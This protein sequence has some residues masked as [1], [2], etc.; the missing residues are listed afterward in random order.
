MLVKLDRDWILRRY[1]AGSDWRLW[2]VEKYY[3]HSRRIG[4][5]LYVYL[6]GTFLRNFKQQISLVYHTSKKL[7][8][9]WLHTKCLFLALS[10]LILSRKVKTHEP[11]QNAYITFK[12]CQ[13]RIRLKTDNVVEANWDSFN[14]LQ[15]HIDS[16]SKVLK[17]TLDKAEKIGL[18]LYEYFEGTFYA[19]LSVVFHRHIMQ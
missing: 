10:F 14:T 18:I 13:L 12:M 3:W 4:R 1:F 5:L 7:N 2:S 6:D 19:I 11:I 16:S 8:S 17:N 15:G 9:F